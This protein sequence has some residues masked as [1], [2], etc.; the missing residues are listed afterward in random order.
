M[1]TKTALETA[2]HIQAIKKDFFDVSLNFFDYFPLILTDNGGEFARVDDIESDFDGQSQLFFCEPNRSDQK[3]RIEK[4]HT[5]LR[6]ILPKGTSFDNLC[7]E[8][9]NLVLSHVNGIKRYAL[10]GKSAYDLF[11]FTYGEKVANILGI[12]EIP[13]TDVV[14]SPKLLKDKI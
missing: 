3:G 2:T 10:N 7:Q 8:D 6:D 1:D 12:S 13:A 14:Q 5:L 11:T 9:I 4:N